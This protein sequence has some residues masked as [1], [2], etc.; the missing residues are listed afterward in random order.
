MENFVRSSD[1]V[2][3]DATI[4]NIDIPYFKE[5]ID[6]IFRL[7]QQLGIPCICIENKYDN[8]DELAEPYYKSQQRYHEPVNIKSSIPITPIFIN[9]KPI[10]RY[11]DKIRRI[12]GAV[13]ADS[14]EY[15]CDYCSKQCDVTEYRF[16][17]YICNKDMCEECNSSLHTQT[18]TLTELIK[19][20]HHLIGKSDERLPII[21]HGK[22]HIGTNCPNENYAFAKYYRYHDRHIKGCFGQIM[23]HMDLC[24]YCHKHQYDNSDDILEDNFDHISD[25]D[26]QDNIEIDQ[27]EINPI[28]NKI[29]TI[30]YHQAE[31][32]T[33]S[34]EY[35]DARCKFGSICDWIQIFHDQYKNA[36]L[37]N[38][39]PISPYY[40]YFGFVDVNKNGYS[41]FWNAFNK[42]ENIDDLMLEYYMAHI[43]DYDYNVP[44]N[45]FDINCCMTRLMLHYDI[46]P[47]ISQN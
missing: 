13:L 21:C 37:C 4:S 33:S 8:L 9:L 25:D 5:L 14:C 28:L 32:D 18:C 36:V 2:L 26:I 3:Y 29:K 7:A 23:Y 46:R 15:Y 38:L 22:E 1:G 19:C 40:K 10:N 24:E 31:G 34:P 27:Y 17:C 45:C 16:Y 41:S 42:F 44:Y 35:I 39:N 43:E 20:S 30:G 6:R 12:N 47:T 11:S